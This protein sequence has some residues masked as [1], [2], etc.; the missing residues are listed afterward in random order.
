MYFTDKIV[1]TRYINCKLSLTATVAG[2]GER[3][4]PVIHTG[5]IQESILSAGHGHHDH[6][7]ISVLCAIFFDSCHNFNSNSIFVII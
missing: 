4:P 1:T 5:H 3:M 6:Q 7:L 2:H